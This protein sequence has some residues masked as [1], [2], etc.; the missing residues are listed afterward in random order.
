MNILWSLLCHHIETEPDGSKNMFGVVED[1]ATNTLPF[2]IDQLTLVFTF[3]T[4]LKGLLP[5]ESVIRLGVHELYRSD[6]GSLNFPLQS[7]EYRSKRLAATTMNLITLPV[8]GEY[9]LD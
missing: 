3:E 8:F 5:F 6:L 9:A 4:G 1:Y 2:E 7:Q